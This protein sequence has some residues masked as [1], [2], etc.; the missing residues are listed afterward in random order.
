MKMK[1][2]NRLFATAAMLGLSAISVFAV[3]SCQKDDDNQ[4]DLTAVIADKPTGDAKVSID[5]D[6]YA[7]WVNGDRVSI[8]GEEYTVGVT[9]SGSTSVSITGVAYNESGYAAVYPS[10]C[11][12]T[13]N[14]GSTSAKIILPDAQEW[15][16]NHIVTPM[17][18]Y[19]TS[20]G[21]GSTL[22]FHNPC[23]LLRVTVTN[24]LEEDLF[25]H[26]IVATSTN[27]ILTGEASVTGLDGTPTISS[28]TGGTKDVTLKCGDQRVSPGEANAY[29]FYVT[30]PKVSGE[31]FRFRVLAKTSGGTKYTFDQ[32]SRAGITLTENQM[33]PI[34]ISLTSDEMQSNS[35]FWGSG[36]S[37]DPYLITD[38]YDLENFRTWVN[39]ITTTNTNYSNVCFRQTANIDYSSA[40]NTWST[41]NGKFSSNYDGGGHTLKLNWGTKPF[42]STSYGAHID[43]LTL[44]GSVNT[45]SAITFGAFVGSALYS[46]GFRE[47]ELNNCINKVNITS[48]YTSSNASYIGG[49]VGLVNGS[50]KCNMTKCKNE[51]IIYKSVASADSYT[52]Y[53]GGLAGQYRGTITDCENNQTVSGGKTTGGFFGT[54]IVVKGESVNSKNITGKYYVG[55]IGGYVASPNISISGSVSNTGDITGSAYNVG[56]IIGFI[57]NGTYTLSIQGAS[58]SGKIY[59]TY[60]VGGI[61][62]KVKGSSKCTL[63]GC[64]NTGTVSG[65]YYVGGIAGYVYSD[66]VGILNCTSVN[67]NVS[68][69]DSI[70][71]RSYYSS[72][73]DGVGGIIGYCSSANWVYI[74]G[75]YNKMAVRAKNGGEKT[76]VG[77]IVGCIY[78]K[79]HV[80]N[81]YNTGSLSGS[82]AYAIGGIVGRT[83]DVDTIVNCYNIGAIS[84]NTSGTGS[85]IGGISGHSRSTVH[86]NNCYSTAVFGD[87][88][89]S[90]NNL[91]IEPSSIPLIIL[92]INFSLISFLLLFIEHFLLKK[93][94]ELQV[95]TQVL[96]LKSIIRDLIFFFNS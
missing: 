71:A 17:V 41:S 62:G 54:W 55:G 61:L 75:C 93:S 86:I 80:C 10:S 78:K 39:A 57:S 33:V 77:G 90:N 96:S 56:G 11:H 24:G 85:G 66:Y 44:I 58:N 42:I 52:E 87:N 12:K 30:V 59:G 15:D 35:N 18:A 20:G 65:T 32:E 6:R 74:E 14:A 26:Q 1:K 92:D 53:V 48:T 27:T 50:T 72:G 82:S 23:N 70:I 34:S 91:S 69:P 89:T 7:C 88:V 2:H 79:G 60:E 51:G 22:L 21:S 36:V 38:T 28:V 4:V 5:E 83:S 29:T 16:E 19:T 64:S 25:I 31:Q 67:S 43:N 9:T 47:T 49:L 95:S 76:T 73:G 3:V 81:C 8:N 46:S 94:L 63:S 37:G 68:E 40:A 45:S 13:E 84:G